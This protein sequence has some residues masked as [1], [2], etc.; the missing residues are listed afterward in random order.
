M[1]TIN[2]VFTVN[3]ILDDCVEVRPEQ[4]HIHD[5]TA[6]ISTIQKKLTTVRAHFFI[7]LNYLYLSIPII[8]I[9][10]YAI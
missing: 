3:H 9:Y 10:T 4:V 2:V 5:S 7:L 8:V 1:Q 6:Q